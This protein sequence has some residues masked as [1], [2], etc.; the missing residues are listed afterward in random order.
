MAKKRKW[1]GAA[2]R[3]V[4]RYN[5]YVKQFNQRVKKLRSQGIEPYEDKALSYRDYKY[6]YSEERNDRI[7]EVDKGQRKSLGD[8]N[9]KI[10][11]DQVYELSEK[12]AYAIFDYM[13]TLSPEERKGI[14][15]NY[16]NI[17]RAIT[18]LREGKFVREELGLWDAI[19]ERRKDLFE[20]GY[21]KNEVASIVSNEFFYPEEDEE[22][23]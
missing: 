23:E 7:K 15:F 10:V 12:Q 19:R 16:K 5:S 2:K 20:A 14:K 4:K 1:S 17:N 18:K 9:K 11:S 3:S 13:K 8:I 22:E 6:I 21:S